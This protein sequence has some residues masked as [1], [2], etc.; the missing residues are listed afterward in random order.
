MIMQH[1]CCYTTGWWKNRQFRDR[2][3]KNRYRTTEKTVGTE[4][5]VAPNPWKKNEKQ[6]AEN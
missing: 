2:N 5:F 3:R 1:E 6:E 4:T